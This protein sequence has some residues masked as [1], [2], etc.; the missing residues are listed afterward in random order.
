MYPVSMEPRFLLI[1]S[2]VNVSLVSLVLSRGLLP[3]PSKKTAGC[4]V[5]LSSGK[6]NKPG[7]PSIPFS[8]SG[9]THDPKDASP[10]I[11]FFCIHNCLRLLNFNE[12]S[13]TSRDRAHSPK[14]QSESDKGGLYSSPLFV[15]RG[16]I[17]LREVCP[18]GLESQ[19]DADAGSWAILLPAVSILN[20]EERDGKESFLLFCMFL[21]HL[22]VYLGWVPHIM[23][24]VTWRSEKNL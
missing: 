11:L 9:T 12:L 20:Q 2:L 10:I 19:R 4:L 24:H 1:T 15:S 21:L 13:Q 14:L 5:L 23:L 22:L 3:H 18:V 17:G 6:L 16:S 7:H 8:Y